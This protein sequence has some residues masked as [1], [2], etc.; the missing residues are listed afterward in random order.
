MAICTPPRRQPR[1]RRRPQ[2]DKGRK[3]ALLRAGLAVAEAALE[4]VVLS[5][6]LSSSYMDE[7][8]SLLNPSTD[9]PLKMNDYRV[10]SNRAVSLEE[11]QA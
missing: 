11:F 9:A 4:G 3:E 8:T 7:A 6:S 10:R 5:E 1:P 2:A